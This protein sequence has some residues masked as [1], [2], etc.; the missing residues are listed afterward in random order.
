MQERRPIAYEK[1]KLQ[2]HERLYSIYDKDMFSIMHAM[3]KFRHYLE[4]SKFI[5]KTDHNN[6]RHFL[7]QKE[8]NDR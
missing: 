4:G 6:L 5:V 1:R 7:T 8:L 2:L 3:A